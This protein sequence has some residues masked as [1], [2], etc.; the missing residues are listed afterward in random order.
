MNSNKKNSRIPETS[1]LVY[2][3]VAGVMY[4]IALALAISSRF[5]ISS[6]LIVPGDA[7]ITTNN[8]MASEGLFRSSIVIW[9]VMQMVYL[10]KPL[11]LYKIFKPVNKNHA[12]LMVILILVAIPI[13]FINELNKFAVLLLLKGG[14]YLTIIGA[15]Q[16]NSQVMFFLDLHEHGIYIA[17]IF[18]GLWLLP[19]GYLVYK[20]DFLP[21]ILGVLLIIGGFGYLIDSL[22]FF[23]FP[24]YKAIVTL[25][26]LGPN[27]ISEF[28]LYIWLLIK[29]VNIE[30]WEKCALESAKADIN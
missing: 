25:I 9:L 18:W 26:V 17:N 16:L 21:R 2:A 29:G 24:S 22:T 23:L 12:V 14:D 19:L 8:I 20:S 27:F 28:A 6:N 7:V 13:A 11:I 4:L 15:D 10:V 1:P 5:L 3:R 30:K